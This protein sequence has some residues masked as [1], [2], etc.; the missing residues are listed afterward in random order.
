[1]LCFPGSQN[2]SAVAVQS[3]EMEQ[4]ND[5]LKLLTAVGDENQHLLTMFSH[6]TLQTTDYQVHLLSTNVDIHHLQI[7]CCE[8]FQHVIE[9][10]EELSK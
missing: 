8:Q 3:Q 10:E 2:A 6:H 7:Y 4:F 5:I 9:L 1:M